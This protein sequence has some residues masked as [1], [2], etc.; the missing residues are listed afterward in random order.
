MLKAVSLITCLYSAR[1]TLMHM[2]EHAPLQV[3]ICASGLGLNIGNHLRL[4]FCHGL[5]G[6]M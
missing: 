6:R 5:H 3:C 1:I 4:Y 2:T